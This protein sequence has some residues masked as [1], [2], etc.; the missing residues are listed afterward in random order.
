MRPPPCC[1]LGSGNCL[2]NICRNIL[3]EFECP[4]FVEEILEHFL[5]DV[6][7]AEDLVA[8]REY[9]GWRL[10]QGIV[11]HGSRDGRKPTINQMDYTALPKTPCQRCCNTK[12][13][14]TNNAPLTNAPSV[15]LIKNEENESAWGV[16]LANAVDTKSCW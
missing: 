13:L 3:V 16:L 10:F 5:C 7:I 14:S 11:A 8:R 6:K 1:G 2:R 9:V 12:Q 4:I 15:M